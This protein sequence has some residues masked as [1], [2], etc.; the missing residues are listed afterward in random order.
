M[1][2][3]FWPSGVQ[4]RTEVVEIESVNVDQSV[5]GRILGYGDIYI[6]GTGGSKERFKY[7]QKPIVFRKRFQELSLH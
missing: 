2:E 7:I 4:P 6:V 5:L 1:A 3:V